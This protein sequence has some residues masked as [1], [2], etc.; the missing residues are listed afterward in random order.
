MMF[1]HKKLRSFLPRAFE[2]Y[3]IDNKTLSIVYK[4]QIQ[5][6][7]NILQGRKHYTNRNHFTIRL[8]TNFW[9]K[10]THINT[11]KYIY[12]W[13][14]IYFIHLNSSLR[15]KLKMSNLSGIE[16]GTTASDP[17]TLP[18]RESCYT[19]KYS[20]YNILFEFWYNLSTF[21]TYITMIIHRRPI[22]INLKSFPRSAFVLI[23]TSPARLV[24]C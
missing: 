11:I 10:G 22:Q 8:K 23:N 7:V 13:N 9:L 2:I 12:Q 18:L 5:S 4:E 20:I 24:C 6:F 15:E 16:P 1:I 17:V 14:K 3:T 19:L 21:K